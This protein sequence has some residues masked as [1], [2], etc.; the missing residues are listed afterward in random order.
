MRYQRRFQTFR[1]GKAQKFLRWA[2]LNFLSL[3]VIAPYSYEHSSARIAL[4][5]VLG[6]SMVV[7]L[8]M[9]LKCHLYESR[10]FFDS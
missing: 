7:L 3:M 6:V 9:A 8:T 1:P 2:G 5:S 10:R 4:I